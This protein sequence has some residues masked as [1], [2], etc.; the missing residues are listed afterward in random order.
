MTQAPLEA[1][2]CGLEPTAVWAHFATL[3]RIPRQSKAEGRLRDELRQ[4]ALARGLVTRIDAAGNLVIRKPASAG[5][6]QAPAVV[7]QAHLDMVCQKT[8]ETS[9]DF[10]RDPIRPVRRDG[11]LLAEGTTLGADNGIGVALIL[12][13]LEDASLPHGPLEALLTV[14][15]EAG[16]GGARGLQGGLLQGRLLLNLDTEEWGELFLGCAGGLDVD[17]QREGR[18]APLPEGFEVWRI[19]LHGLRGGHSGVDIHAERGQRHQ[20]PGACPAGDWSVAGRCGWR[21]SAVARRAMRCPAKPRQSSRCRPGR[22]MRWRQAWPRG[23]RCCA[24]N[25]AASMKG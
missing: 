4:W 17:V 2:F 12:A 1:V 11:W 25:C 3:C 20:A 15:E 14:D 23:S 7:L 9:H 10:S 5:R 24:R 18:P 13:V 8:P 22:A 16:M 19:E 21:N 6:E